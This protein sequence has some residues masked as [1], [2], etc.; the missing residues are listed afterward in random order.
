[1]SHSNLSYRCYILPIIAA[2]I[3]YILALPPV[4]DMINNWIPDYYYANMA[5]SLILLI[6]LFISCRIMDIIWVD[7][8]HDDICTNSLSTEEFD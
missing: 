3:Y 5:K 7:M 2:I 8:C 6:I 4:V 1:M